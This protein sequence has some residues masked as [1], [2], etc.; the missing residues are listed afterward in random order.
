MNGTIRCKCGKDVEINIVDS[1]SLTLSFFG[2]L[3]PEKK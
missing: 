2:D 1:K 3:H